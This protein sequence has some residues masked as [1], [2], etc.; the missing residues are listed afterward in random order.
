MEGLLR[1]RPQVRA[2]LMGVNAAVVGL[3]L[4]ALWDPV[5]PSGILGLDDALLAVLALLGLMRWKWPPW[6]LVAAYAGMGAL[7]TL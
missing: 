4:A 3:L 1:A 5:I 6:V 2:A 7:V